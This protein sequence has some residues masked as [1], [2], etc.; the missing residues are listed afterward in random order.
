M[1][2]I[3]K[4]KELLDVARSLAKERHKGQKRWNGDDYY[5][6]HLVRVSREVGKKYLQA[7]LPTESQVIRG[8]K[9]SIVG[10]L[11][12]IEEDTPTTNEEIVSLFGMEI[13]H[14]VSCITHLLGESYEDY[15]KKVC[16][17]DLAVEVKMEDLTHNMETVTGN[18]GKL[19]AM[20]YEYLV[21]W[22]RYVARCS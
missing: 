10:I 8:Y 14:A 7:N 17:S 6:T 19:Y 3:E 16:K 21:L 5:Q 9:L 12:D 22:K 20:A 18:K 11:H 2:E 15:I 1:S 4:Y 13:G